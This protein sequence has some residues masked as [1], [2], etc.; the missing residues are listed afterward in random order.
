MNLCESKVKGYVCEEPTD[1]CANVGNHWITICPECF[2]Y[3]VDLW[4]NQTGDL[5]KIVDVFHQNNGAGI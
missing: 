2:D 3:R 1:R 4:L 5:K